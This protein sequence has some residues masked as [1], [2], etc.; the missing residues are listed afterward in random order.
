MK[1]GG[2]NLIGLLNLNGSLYRGVAFHEPY[3]FRHLLRKQEHGNFS[4]LI[5]LGEILVEKLKRIKTLQGSLNNFGIS[6]FLEK[7]LRKS[8]SRLL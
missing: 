3:E 2:E 5:G 1:K 6:P 7:F 4:D 8:S